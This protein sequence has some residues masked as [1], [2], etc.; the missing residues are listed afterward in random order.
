MK[1]LALSIVATAAASANAGFVDMKYLGAGEGSNVRITLNGNSSNVF[2]GQLRHR[3]TNG[4]G[5]DAALNGDH[6][7]FCAD[8]YQTVSSSYTAYEIV[9][10]DQVSNSHPMGNVKAGAIRAIYTASGSAALQNGAA[11]S[12]AT[13]FQLAIWEIV[14]DFDGTLASLS[15]TAGDFKAKK[16]DGSALSSTVQSYLGTFFAAAVSNNE[17]AP[18]LVGLRSDC[19]Q[20]Q[21]LMGYSI[22][23]PGTAVLAGL[24]ALCVGRR[25][26]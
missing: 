20:D 13:A 22:P 15:V 9:E 26:R 4:S 7:T 19:A 17:G 3:I 2:A 12:L 14:T 18:Q 5:A 6:R 25:R 1:I 8:L 21:L 24:G 10:I 23:T 11:S 16:T